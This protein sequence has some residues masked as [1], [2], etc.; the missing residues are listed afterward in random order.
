MVDRELAYITFTG[1]AGAHRALRSPRALKGPNGT[2]L[3]VLRPGR[4]PRGSPDPVGSIWCQYRAKQ[5]HGD[6]FRTI[7]G[8][9]D[10]E[11]V[12]WTQLA[13]PWDSPLGSQSPKYRFSYVV[14]MVAARNLDFPYV[15]KG[16]QSRFFEYAPSEIIGQEFSSG[17]RGNGVR[18]CGSDAAFHTQESQDDV[19]S[20]ANSLKRGKTRL[21]P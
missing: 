5:R 8:V 16:S 10:Q 2:F 9:S 1:Q 11:L 19:S 4:H 18:S 15:F 14:F 17:S 7:F 13:H 3:A 21:L 6:L 20:Q 12:F